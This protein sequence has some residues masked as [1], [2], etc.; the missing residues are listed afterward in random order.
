MK[1]Y[2]NLLAHVMENGVDRS[3]R[4][5]VGTRS[6]F[7]HQM[8]FDLQQG[9]P[10]L[11]TKKIHWKSVVHELL[12]FLSGQ[13]NI[14]YLQQNGVRIWN[15]WATADGELGPVYGAQWRHW[16]TD[17]GV[18]VDQISNVINDIKKRPN[19]RRLLVS[20]WNPSVLPDEARSPQ[21]NV[22]V[23]KMALAPCH[24]LIQFYVADNKLSCMLTQRSVDCF[25]GLA[26]NIPSY[27][28]LT[29]MIAQQC[30]LD[31]GEFIWSGGDVHIYHNHFEQ[32]ALQLKRTPSALPKLDIQRHRES[33][34]AYQ[35]E[36]FQLQGYQPQAHIA[37]PVAV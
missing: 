26:F 8:R 25:L 18:E 3:D 16:Q 12:W 24:V 21:E 14:A 6:V 30:E 32:V 29:H 13:T 2:L 10:L 7:G 36:D 17:R 37:A 11:T 28:L 9:F 23:G 15:E 31:V 27:A 22:Q 35:F 33:I 34:F 19:S 5:G 20:A 1:Q 4:T